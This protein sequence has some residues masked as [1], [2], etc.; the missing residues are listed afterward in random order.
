M[1]SSLFSNILI[2]FKLKSLKDLN[3]WKIFV[4]L[5]NWNKSTDLVSI[6][7]QFP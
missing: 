5:L 4:L 3:F 1:L 2:S 6:W 7:K